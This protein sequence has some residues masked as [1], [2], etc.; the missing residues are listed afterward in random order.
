[1]ELTEDLYKE[2]QEM[3]GT[4]LVNPEVF[5]MTFRNQVK[6]FLYEKKL[7]ELKQ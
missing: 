3:F 1:M 6:L 7:K 4:R 5:P 2:F